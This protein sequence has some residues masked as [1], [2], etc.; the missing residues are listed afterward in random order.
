[1]EIK[2]QFDFL[3]GPIWPNKFSASNGLATGVVA[4]DSDL[5]LNVLNTAG[6]D[7]YSSLFSF[8]KK[9]SC[10]FNELKFNAIKKDLLSIVQTIKERL[11]AI[12]DG[13]FIVIDRATEDIL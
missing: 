9:G 5:A 4:V 12:N 2:L 11:N 3:H 8:D 1:M 6:Q 13:S 7:L 10:T